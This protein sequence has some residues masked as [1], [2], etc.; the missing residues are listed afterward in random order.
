MWRTLSG[1][2]I[3]D[4]FA[5]LRSLVQEGRIL[6][7]GTDAK[8]RGLHTDFVTVIA[9]LTPH[10]GGRVFYRRE[11][12]RR[13]RSLAEQL[14]REVTLSIDVANTLSDA[15]ASPITVHVD[16]NAD[17]RHRSAHYVQALSGMVMGYG[18]EVKVKPEAWCATHVADFV[19][20]EK[21]Q[22]AA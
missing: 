21:N 14:F 6:H 13:M 4:L 9:V 10:L 5:E 19:V 16:A 15:I 12:T 3:R 1:V 22:R 8:H 11:R 2:P 17:Q 20:K 7:V 18:Y